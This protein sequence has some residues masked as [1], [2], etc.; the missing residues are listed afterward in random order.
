M[1]ALYKGYTGGGDF[2]YSAKK[3]NPAFM[4]QDQ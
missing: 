3:K 1:I 2:C 4:A